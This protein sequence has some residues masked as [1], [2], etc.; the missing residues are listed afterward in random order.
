MEWLIVAVLAAAGG[1]LGRRTWRGRGRRRELALEQAQE[2]ETA[3]TLADEDVTVLGEQLRRLD[4]EVAG[5]PLDEAARLDYQAA[6]DAYESA[7]RAVPAMRS[8]E[9][10][11]RVSDIL[12]GGR[13][14]L[15]CVQARVAG[16][17]LPARRTPCFFNPQH[18]PATVDVTWNPPAHGTRIVPACAQD[19][20]RIARGER[21]DL[22]RV[23]VNGQML[24]YWEAGAA[25]LPY[26]KDYFTAA[27]LTMLGPHS[28]VGGGIT[29]FG[30][31]IGS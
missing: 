6:L 28:Q 15:A 31:G 29:S 19:A 16:R 8:V 2:L 9:E 17:P 20:A 25:Y 12:T 3:R 13:Y 4:A 26:G 21:P 7:Q 14:A 30:G 10:V 11:T 1:A 27:A 18:G 23:K 24:P 22:R 5:H